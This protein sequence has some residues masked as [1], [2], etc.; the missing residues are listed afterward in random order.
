MNPFAQDSLNYTNAIWDDGEWVSWDLINQY[1]EEADGGGSIEWDETES[2]EDELTLSDLDDF[3]ARDLS[4]QD[5]KFHPGKTCM[6]KLEWLEAY[7][8]IA[9][10]MHGEG[11][12]IGALVGKLGEFFAS[13]R[14]GMSPHLKGNAQG[15]DGKIG[16]DFVEVKTISPWKINPVVYVKRSGHFNKLIVVKINEQWIFDARIVDRTMLPKG[17][18]AKK[19][20]VHWDS[21]ALSQSI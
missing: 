13:T 11:K 4:P 21:K 16:D 17:R 10:R 5:I 12:D 15:S 18:V 1:A 8:S 6:E 3:D 19:I 7:I 2:D 14:F 20:Q 9:Q